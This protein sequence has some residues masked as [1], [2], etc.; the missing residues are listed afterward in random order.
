MNNLTGFLKWMADTRDQILKHDRTSLQ[1]LSENIATII[2]KDNNVKLSK[3]L[4]SIANDLQISYKRS[5]KV[6]EPR[7]DL[8]S[9]EQMDLVSGRF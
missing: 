5:F 7:T 6:E 4:S 8:P 3:F 9:F 1:V 2:E